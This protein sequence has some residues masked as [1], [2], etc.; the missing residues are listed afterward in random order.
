MTPRKKKDKTPTTEDLAKANLLD[1]LR[2][3]AALVE[4]PSRSTVRSQVAGMGGIS[5]QTRNFLEGMPLNDKHW[6]Q[7]L[8]LAATDLNGNGRAAGD[9]I[10]LLL[11]GAKAFGDAERLD[12]A[13]NCIARAYS[14][15]AVAHREIMRQREQA[16]TRNKP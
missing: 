2:P 16:N 3:L 4:A 6:K 5:N 8:F 1:R 15:P 11:S 14:K 13:L 9:V 7:N 12:E 10:Y